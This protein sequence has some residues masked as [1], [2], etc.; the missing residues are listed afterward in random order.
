MLIKRQIFTRD[1]GA[2]NTRIKE[3]A[4]LKDRSG[5]YH[6]SLFTGAKAGKMRLS[7]QE[8]AIYDYQAFEKMEGMCFLLEDE[9]YQ[10]VTHHDTYCSGE[11]IGLFNDTPSEL[12]TLTCHTSAYYALTPHGQHAIITIGYEGL[13]DVT[14]TTGEGQTIEINA[15]DMQACHALFSIGQWDSF[16]LEGMVDAQGRLSVIDVLRINN[17][18]CKQ[19]YD[20]RM[21]LL[22]RFSPELTLAKVIHNKADI[23]TVS[24]NKHNCAIWLKQDSP[25]HARYYAHT[26]LLGEFKVR[27]QHT[28][29]GNANVIHDVMID[30]QIIGQLTHPSRIDSVDNVVLGFVEHQGKKGQFCLADENYEYT[31]PAYIAAYQCDWFDLFGDIGDA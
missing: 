27:P 10:C 18:V 23:E 5:R 8:S 24:D 30:E 6:V 22:A 17:I 31:P 19:T 21:A 16:V 9:G 26:H 2:P 3:V 11:S 1:Y 4:C 14:V 25:G 29:D 13:N 28:T 20:K 15:H 7:Q 12:T